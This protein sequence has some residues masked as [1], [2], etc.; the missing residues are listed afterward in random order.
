LDEV[1]D[2]SLYTIAENNS[3]QL[4]ADRLE[5]TIANT[6]SIWHEDLDLVKDMYNDIVVLNNEK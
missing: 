2:Y 6:Y 5:Y 4:S 1:D 3:P